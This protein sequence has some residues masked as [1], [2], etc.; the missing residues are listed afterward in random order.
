[1][2]VP[3]AALADLQHVANAGGSPAIALARIAGGEIVIVAIVFST[4]AAVLVPLV[5]AA[6]KRLERSGDQSL[7]VP[8]EVTQ[9]LE[10]IETAVESIALEVERISEGQ[11]FVTQLMSKPDTPRIGRGADT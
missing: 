6:A 2:I 9:R 4:A 11:R 8:L 1:M 5:R 7:G 3:F 10:R